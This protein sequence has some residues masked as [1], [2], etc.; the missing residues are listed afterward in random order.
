MTAAETITQF[1]GNIDILESLK[2]NV[3]D[4]IVGPINNYLTSNFAGYEWAIVL[5]VAIGLGWLIESQVMNSK[6]LRYILIILIYV[7]L[8]YLGVGG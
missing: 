1:T 4:K 5:G 7:V 3:F 8:K 2:V 6:T